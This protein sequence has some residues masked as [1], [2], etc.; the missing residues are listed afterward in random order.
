ML[1]NYPCIQVQSVLIY[2][3]VVDGGDLRVEQDLGGCVGCIGSDYRMGQMDQLAG[4]VD[5]GG[6]GE[7]HLGLNFL[8]QGTVDKR[9]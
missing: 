5:I 6:G 9:E 1:Q 4:Y 3:G 2:V 7:D 8:D